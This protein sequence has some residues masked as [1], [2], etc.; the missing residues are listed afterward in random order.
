MRGVSLPP[1]RAIFSSMARL[2]GRSNSFTGTLC[3]K[4]SLVGGSIPRSIS[5]C[6]SSRCQNMPRGPCV[7]PHRIPQRSIP[8][9]HSDRFL[10]HINSL[11]A[12]PRRRTRR[13][14]AS[15]WRR[16]PRG[17][18]PW[19][20]ACS[21]RSTFSTCPAREADLSPSPAF[22][23]LCSF[24]ILGRDRAIPMPGQEQGIIGIV[25]SCDAY[26]KAQTFSGQN[27][28][29]IQGRWLRASCQRKESH[30][31]WRKLNIFYLNHLQVR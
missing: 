10:L 6:N 23:S 21:W 13:R 27:F 5:N 2:G 15:R 30:L 31:H 4:S 26:R 22:S 28:T 19:T 25:A 24:S 1:A 8:R 18:T 9:E 3:R 29:P 16:T 12:S 11:R 17:Q 14:R 7:F 20:C